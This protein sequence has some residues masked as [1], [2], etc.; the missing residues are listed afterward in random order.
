MTLEEQI[1][2]RMAAEIINQAGESGA[3]I[4]DDLPHWLIGLAPRLA[5]AVVGLIRQGPQLTWDRLSLADD[6][7]DFYVD[8]KSM[9]YGHPLKGNPVRYAVVELE[10]A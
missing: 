4:P 7:P 2:Q 5:A 1:A 3:K 8:D 9:L 6:F 10:D